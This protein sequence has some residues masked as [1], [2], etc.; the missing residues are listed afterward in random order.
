MGNKLN[1]L[2]I[3]IETFKNFYSEYNVSLTPKYSVILSKINFEKISLKTYLKMNNIIYTEKYIYNI[4][5]LILFDFY[6]YM[7][8]FD[9]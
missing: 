1:Q 5:K 3:Y 4:N 9:F 7:F 6:N 8:N 2:R